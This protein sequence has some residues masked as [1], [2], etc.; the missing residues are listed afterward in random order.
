MGIHCNG[1]GLYT[2]EARERQ[3]QYAT[4]DDYAMHASFGSVILI[5]FILFGMKLT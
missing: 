3:D 4:D 1:V 2:R 5:A